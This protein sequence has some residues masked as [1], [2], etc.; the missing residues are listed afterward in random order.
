MTRDSS[1]SATLAISVPLFYAR[2]RRPP[3]TYEGS[4]LGLQNLRLMLKISYAGCF[5]LGLY[6][7]AFRRN[8]LL[9]CALQPKMAKNSLKAP[10]GGFKVVQGHRC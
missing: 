2:V 5:D 9:K 1:S 8:S 10:F 3:R 4:A 7:Q 6:L